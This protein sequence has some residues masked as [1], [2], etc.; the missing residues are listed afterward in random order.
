MLVVRETRIDGLAEG[1]EGSF[2]KGPGEVSRLPRPPL[3]PNQCTYCN[4]RI[5]EKLAPELLG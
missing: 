4:K 2:Q 5:L 1:N 3:A